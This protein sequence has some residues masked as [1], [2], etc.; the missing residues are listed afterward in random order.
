MSVASQP[1]VREITELV[2]SG[3][4]EVDPVT[5]AEAMVSRMVWDDIPDL[6]PWITAG[7]RRRQQPRL[8]GVVKLRRVIAGPMPPTAL[9]A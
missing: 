4:Y 3:E 5:V 2:G 7:T 6:T 8:R 1:K 9:S